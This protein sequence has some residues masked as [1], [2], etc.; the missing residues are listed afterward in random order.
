[1][2]RNGY[3]KSNNEWKKIKAGFVKV[4]N[5]WKAVDAGYVKKDSQWRQF[6]PSD[7]LVYGFEIDLSGNVS[8]PKKIFEQENMAYGTIPCTNENNTFQINGFAGCPLITGIKRQRL[9]QNGWE[10]I[11]DKRVAYAGSSNDEVYTYFPTW[12]IKTEYKS[13]RYYFAFSIKQIDST[14]MDVAGSFEGVRIGHF[15]LGCYPSSFSAVYE[16]PHPYTSAGYPDFDVRM[17]TATSG[18]TNKG[19]GWD[20]MIYSQWTYIVLLMI[21]LFKTVDIKSAL[22]NGI[23]NTSSRQGVSALSFTNDYGMYGDIS[24]KSEPVSFF[25]LHNIYGYSKQLCGGLRI[26]TTRDTTGTLIEAYYFD[27]KR[28]SDSFDVTDDAIYATGI[29]VADTIGYV[30]GITS[31]TKIGFIP[32][33]ASTQKSYYSGYMEIYGSRGANETDGVVVG[34]S[35]SDNDRSGP[36]TLESYPNKTGVLR[37]SYRL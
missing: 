24:N 22:G 9:S 6:Y 33:L 15:R 28:Y 12:F 31:A 1:M 7:N 25:W 18:C 27:S 4:D 26:I 21:L 37:L 29:K 10:D 20:P 3:I 16:T 32:T 14:W 2:G 23:C 17:I 36:F 8:Y 11:S 30:K 35:Y 13:Y 19:P 34:G 5:S